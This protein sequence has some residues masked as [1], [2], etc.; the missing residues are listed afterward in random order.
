MNKN[1]LRVLQ[2][3]TTWLNLRPGV[4]GV[5]IKRLKEWLSLYTVQMVSK[6]EYDELLLKYEDSVL[7]RAEL[8]DKYVEL[9][10]KINE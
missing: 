1:T 10:G 6:Q 9:R 8:V 5:N 3:Y 4:K 2:L 7:K